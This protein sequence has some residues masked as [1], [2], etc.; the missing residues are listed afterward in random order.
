MK[1]VNAKYKKRQSDIVT[2]CQRVI[3]NMENNPAFPNPPAALAELKKVL[4]EFQNALVKAE[5]RDK[6]MVSIKNDKKAIV[7]AYLQEL[8]DYVTVTCNNDRTLILGSGFDATNEIIGSSYPT[9][10]I[11]ILEVELGAPGE[12]TTRAKKV[13]GIVAYVHQYTKE[14]PSI[15][16][17]WIGI[18]SNQNSHTF[19]GL[20]SDKRY[21]FRIVAI[22]TD[23]RR[24]YSP[25]VSKVIQ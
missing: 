25:V 14:L 3:E 22:G 13:S 12:V 21:W 17:E 5:G 6:Q 11:E 1:K 8:S 16:T 20:I 23:G 15:N 9:P 19:E 7:L 24:G 18:G 2:I 4:P 10:S